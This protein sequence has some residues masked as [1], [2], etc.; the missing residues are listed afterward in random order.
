MLNVTS[1]T[2]TSVPTILATC[3]QTRFHL[4]DDNPSAEVDVEGLGI[5][6]ASATS[7]STDEGSKTKPKGKS[8]A[9]AQGKELLNDA[10]LRLKAGI[11]YGLLGRNGTGKST[12]LRAMAEKLIPGI[13]HATRISILQQIDGEYTAGGTD[14][15]SL[16]KGVLQSVLSSDETRNEAVRIADCRPHL[17]V[18]ASRHVF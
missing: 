14:G 15:L 3:K 4:L 7:E 16:E 10:H 5:T 1:H 2:M 6:V 17:P 18:T 9:K 12:L 8:K 11:R 13:T